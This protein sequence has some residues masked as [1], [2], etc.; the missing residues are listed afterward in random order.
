MTVHPLL[1][2]AAARRTVPTRSPVQLALATALIAG[3][4]AIVPWLVVLAHTLPAT[5]TARHWPIAWIGLDVLQAIG[6]AATGALLLRRDSRHAATAA[7][8]ASALALDAWM[9]V[10]T[11]TPGAGLTAAVVLAV[12]LELPLAALCAGVALRGCGRFSD[13]VRPGRAAR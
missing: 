8:T 6:L 9:D 7:A 2:P 13:G 4:A 5:A 11:A 12:A 10:T 3:A 1:A